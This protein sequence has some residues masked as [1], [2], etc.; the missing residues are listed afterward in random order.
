M[1]IYQE[2]ELEA[3]PGLP[4]P[5][6]AGEHILWQGAPDWWQLANDAFHVRRISIY[7]ALMLA[8]QVLLSWEP[9]AGVIA[10]LAPLSLSATLA[11]LALGLLSLTAW[12]SARTTMYTLTNRRVVMRI[13]IVLTVSFNFPLRWIAAAHMKPAANGCGDIAL[14]LK[15]ADRIGYLHLW[16]HARAW[17]LKKPQP[18]LRSLKDA[19]AVG[20]LLH[21]A[22]R[23]R[24]SEIGAIEPQERIPVRMPASAIA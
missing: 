10:N 3:V 2:H 7:F 14:E 21:K 20:E 6:P 12:L 8:L 11:G 17:E 19:A 23:A 5:L 18:Q 16:P 4:E 24:L 9:E 13:G 1:Q 22:W 15:G